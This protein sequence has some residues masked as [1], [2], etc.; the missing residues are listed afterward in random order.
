MFD[1]FYDPG[2]S[3]TLEKTIKFTNAL[4]ADVRSN[5]LNLWDD[6][7]ERRVLL[8][9]M[10][11]DDEKPILDD[12]WALYFDDQSVYDRLLRIKQ[13]LDPDH[14]FTANLFEV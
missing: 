1:I 11:V 6:D 12:Q 8:G 14:V 5:K 3:G 7:K 9:P 13:E 4:A 2:V 10:L